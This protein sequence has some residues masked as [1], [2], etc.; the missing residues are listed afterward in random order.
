MSGI[1]TI[2]KGL[3]GNVTKIIVIAIIV[4]FIGSVGWA[5]FFSQGSANVVVTVGDQE[6]TTTDLSFEYSSQQ[7]LLSERF[8]DQIIEEI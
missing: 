1:Q 3:T 5:G 4:T 6:I 2:R 7:D 8:P